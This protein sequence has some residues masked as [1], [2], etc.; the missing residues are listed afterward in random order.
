MDAL[1]LDFTHPPRRAV[2]MAWVLLVAGA[3]TFATAA[4]RHADLGDK[5]EH[6][7]DKIEKLQ[8]RAKSATPVRR[9]AEAAA[10]EEGA[11]K[12]NQLLGQLESP[13]DDRLKAVASAADESVALLDFSLDAV[14]AKARIVAEA[15]NIDDALAFVARLRQTGRFDQVTLSRHESRKSGGVDVIGFNLQLSWRKS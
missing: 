5:A 9:Q 13:W 2:P 15:K 14:A 12:E 8:R 3:V 7:N 4:D 11:R 1:Q 10:K 6:L